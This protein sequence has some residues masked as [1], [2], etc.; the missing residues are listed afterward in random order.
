LSQLNAKDNYSAEVTKQSVARYGIVDQLVSSGLI[1]DPTL[2]SYDHD[3]YDRQWQ[4][5]LDNK[6]SVGATSYA[7]VTLTD[8][9]GDKSAVT[10]KGDTIYDV[11]P[12]KDSDDVIISPNG[13]NGKIG[14]AGRRVVR[15]SSTDG[16]GA[17]VFAG[18]YPDQGTDSKPSRMIP[19]SQNAS[20]DAGTIN[21]LAQGSQGR[22]TSDSQ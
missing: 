10:P 4:G 15:H 14:S 17:V 6:E 20:K 7:T 1:P 22:L 16:Q 2:V 21:S 3:L 12:I 18:P 5:A 19:F 11:T 9:V 8:T 13:D